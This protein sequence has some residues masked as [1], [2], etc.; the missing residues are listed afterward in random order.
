MS[1]VLKI[2]LVAF[3]S[4]EFYVIFSRKHPIVSIKHVLNDFALDPTSVGE[5]WN[6]LDRG[7][8]IALGFMVLNST[9]NAN[10]TS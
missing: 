3:I 2:V 6:P 9:L 4:F 7:F 8:D 10:L 1:L 5:G